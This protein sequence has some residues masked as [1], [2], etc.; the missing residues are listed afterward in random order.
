MAVEYCGIAVEVVVPVC[1]CGDMGLD[2]PAAGTSVGGVSL[3]RALIMSISFLTAMKITWARSNVFVGGRKV[4][5]K[6]WLRI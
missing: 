6:D 2:V 1:K 4:L 5:S 3:A